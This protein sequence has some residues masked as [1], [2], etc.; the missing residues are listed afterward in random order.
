MNHWHI[1]RGSGVGTPSFFWPINAFE[2]GHIV[3][4]PPSFYPGLGTPLFKMAGSAPVNQTLKELINLL[5]FFK[6][7]K[8]SFSYKHSKLF[9]LIFKYLT[10]HWF[11]KN[12]IYIFNRHT[13]MHTPMRQTKKKVHY[14]YISWKFSLS[15]LWR[16]E[17]FLW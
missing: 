17:H 1:Q 16:P 5:F 12:N 14:I 7:V 11:C 6:L 15:R 10:P 13:A 4:T 3:G 9:Y 2:W 8:H